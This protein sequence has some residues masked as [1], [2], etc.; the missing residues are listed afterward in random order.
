MVSRFKQI[1]EKAYEKHCIL[2]ED[3]KAD[4][5]LLELAFDTF[6][7]IKKRAK[8][9]AAEVKPHLKDGMLTLDDNIEDLTLFKVDS[10]YGP[11]TL[12]ID[13]VSDGDTVKGRWQELN[14]TMIINLH[15]IFGFKSESNIGIDDEDEF[16][17][18]TVQ[19]I[20]DEKSGMYVDAMYIDDYIGYLCDSWTFRIFL[21]EFTHLVDH[22]EKKH[23]YQPNREYN[24]R[25]AEKNAWFMTKMFDV[26]AQ[27]INEYGKALKDLTP[28]ER[29]SF[30]K[31]KWNKDE[32]FMKYYN[33]LQ[34]KD[35]KRFL[36]RLYSYFSTDHWNNN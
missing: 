35:Q 32:H 28:E 9:K 33:K 6:D 14:K 31:N 4:R 8:N 18:D 2:L 1:V 7:D 13:S 29:L 26:T 23:M 17:D 11:F 20:Y 5:A 10:K 16:V 24:D 27:L 36:S 21:H 12:I 19:S 22:S 25:D 15:N 30:M 34:P 3:A